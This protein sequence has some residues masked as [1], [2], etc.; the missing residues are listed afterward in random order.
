MQAQDQQQRRSFLKAAARAG[1]AGGL[2]Y[3][4]TLAQLA[5]GMRW[6]EGPVYFPETV[7]GVGGHLLLSDIPNNRIMKYSEKDGGFSTHRGGANHA[8]GNTR[9][10]QGRL[11]SGEHSVMRRITRTER[12]GKI[13]VLAN[14]FEGK[15][16]TAPNDII[17]KSD[18]SVCFSNPQDQA[19]R[20]RRPGC[21][22]RLPGRPRRQAVVRL[23]Q[24]GCAAGRAR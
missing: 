16:L 21:T 9:D 11:R 4:S 3:S 12:D 15:R 5:T 7:A 24:Q 10:R 23:G 20:R 14:S 13:S 17:V 1:L 8:N 22:G 19:D 18:D 2:A 6:A